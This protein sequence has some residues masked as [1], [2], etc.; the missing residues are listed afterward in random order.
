MEM[1]IIDFLPLLHWQT[2]NWEIITDP[3][4]HNLLAIPFGIFVI[5]ALLALGKFYDWVGGAKVVHLT[6]RVERW[7]IALVSLV[8]ALL[9]AVITYIYWVIIGPGDHPFQWPV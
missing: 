9:V 2:D 4:V 5:V 3:E 6:I 7:H 8:S 1:D